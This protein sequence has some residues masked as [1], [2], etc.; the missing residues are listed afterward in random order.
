M[1]PA[2]YP[3]WAVRLGDR[4]LA[5]ELMDE[6]YGKYQ[7]GRFSQTLE[8]RLDRVPDGTPAGPFFAN[9]GGFLTTLLL[10]LTGL[11]CKAGPPETWPQRAVVLPHGWTAIRCDQVWVGG[12]PARLRAEHGAPRAELTWL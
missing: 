9:I 7:S 12:R 2:L 10:G 6:G 8:Y 5:L 4:K 11:S 1:L 3:A